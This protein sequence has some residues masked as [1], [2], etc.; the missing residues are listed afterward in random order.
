[1]DKYAVIGHPISHS[2]SPRIHTLFAQQTGQ[3][4]TY[5]AILAPL[6]EF[7]QTVESFRAHG[8]RGMSVTVPFK[9]EAYRMATRLSDRAQAAGAVN[10]LIFEEGGI[11]GENTDGAGLVRDITQ[12]LSRTITGRRILLVGAG[13]A[14]RGVILPLL[15]MKPSEL[16][17]T[18]RTAPKAEALARTFGIESCPMDAL[19]LSP[20]AF[21]LVINATSSGL[22]EAALDLPDSVFA[23]GCLA[24]DMMYGRL[25]PF[26]AQAHAAHARVADGLGMLVE[27]A[28][29]AFFLWRGVR[30]V[31]EP[32][33]AALK[34]TS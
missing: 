12:N 7:R 32:V 20:R 29:E 14:A 19:F 31:S 34:G 22:S 3:V 17:I 26:M 5:E 8:G 25:T 18:N 13:G 4:M 23:P 24:Y 28:S 30:P 11:L 21:D 33:L 6:T 10:T 16:V 27:Q 15:N 2:Q 9:E 1:M